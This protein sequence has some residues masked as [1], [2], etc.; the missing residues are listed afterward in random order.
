MD[1]VGLTVLLKEV[2]ADSAVIQN[3]AQEAASHLTENSRGRLKAC[4]FEMARLYNTFE[5]ILER[6]CIAFEN[7][8]KK[9][10]DYHERLLER[11]ALALPGIRPVFIPKEFLSSLGELKGF[12]HVVRHAYNLELRE[13]RLKELVTLAD[14]LA[15]QLPR[16]AEDFGKQV[17]A[18]QSWK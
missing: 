1:A 14:Q 6:I 7:H 13:D 18:E 12:S 11:L 9:W 10:G 17:R 15:A 16:W 4:A 8:F 3:A 2:Q 5:K